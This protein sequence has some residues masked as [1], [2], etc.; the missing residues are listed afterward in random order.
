MCAPECLWLY[1]ADGHCDKA[2][3]NIK[4]Q[5][6]GGDC[7]DTSKP[8]LGDVI[9]K[10]EDYDEVETNYT[11]LLATLQNTTTRTFKV[12]HTVN[13]SNL[14]SQHNKKVL[15]LDKL[16]RRKLRKKFSQRVYN[17]NVDAYADS[18][19][20]TNRIL[21][22]FYGFSVRKVP[23][24]APIMVDREIMEQ[25]QMKFAKYF[26]KTAW[27]RVRSVDDIQFS[28]AYYYFL[29]HE[30]NEFSID[31]IFDQFDTDMSGFVKQF[32]RI[33]PQILLTFCREWSDVEVRTVVTKLYDLPITDEIFA[34]FTHMLVNCSSRSVL[35]TLHI[36]KEFVRNCPLL[37]TFL[38]LNLAITHKYKFELIKEADK[39]HVS[40]K[41]LNSNVTQVIRQLDDVRKNVK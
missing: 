28:F 32:V 41:M 1:V 14:I 37:S 4:C 15:F 13:I 40:F 6:D 30:K 22:E 31:E 11:K 16:K 3:N 27:N 5:M 36:T 33:G 38:K 24:H 20:H 39:K 9:V 12:D 10:F 26:Q 8:L 7:D 29:I 23:A 18:L 35:P 2:C 25:M 17:R 21:N 19:Q 34:H